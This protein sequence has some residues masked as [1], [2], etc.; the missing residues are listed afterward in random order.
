MDIMREQREESCL[1][2]SQERVEW[3]LLMSF[4]GGVNQNGYVVDE[5]G[6]VIT[7]NNGEN[8]RKKEIVY[9]KPTS[10]LPLEVRNGKIL[11]D[12]DYQ[13]IGRIK[14]RLYTFTH[15]RANG[16]ILTK[17]SDIPLIERISDGRS[18]LNRKV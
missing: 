1:G 7:N 4:D 9:T 13:N 6:D 18:K 3:M 10:S 2:F 15:Q 17:E 12:N 5:N 16:V 14:D 8:L 11:Y